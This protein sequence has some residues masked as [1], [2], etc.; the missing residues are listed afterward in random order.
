MSITVSVSSPGV[1]A[2][3]SG[4]V[5]SASVSA[6]STIGATVAGGIGPAGAAGTTTIS[7][8]SD[9]QLSSVTDGDVL[10]YSASKWRNYA[11]SNLTDGG[12]F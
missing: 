5:V 10:R 2:N 7:G 1:S 9:V 3:V 11:D 6:P 4:G 8:A 12:N